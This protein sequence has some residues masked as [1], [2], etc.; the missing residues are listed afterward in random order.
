MAS[1]TANDQ[2]LTL[3]TKNSDIFM[4]LG[5]I[6]ILV[7]MILPLPTWLLDILLS[8][9]I[10]LAIIVLL[11]SMYVMQ[12]L[13]I[14]SFP[15]LLLLTTLFRLGLNI[16]STRL[17]LLNGDQGD[18]AA[19]QVIKA[20]GG[21]V[22]GGNY[23][24]G[25]VVFAI[26]VIINFT[27]ITK[28]AGR[29]AE[30]AARFT[31]DA[32]P[33]RQMSIDA[34][35]NN[36]LIDENEAREKRDRIQ[37]ESDFYGA[38]DGASK[39][40]RGDAV[41]GIIITFINIIGGLFIGVVQKDMSFA[42]AAQTYTLLTVGDGLVSQIPALIISTSAGFIVSRAASDGHMGTQ[43]IS[44]LTIHPRAFVVAA[45][46]LT[47]FGLVPGLPTVPFFG[48]AILAAG[49][50]Y[51]IFQAEKTTQDEATSS[52]EKP[53]V[54]PENVEALLSVDDLELEVG[55]GLIPLV[56]KDQ[57]GDLL[58]RIRSLRRQFA[59][60][61]GVI[62]PPIHIRDNLQL[63]PNQYSFLV[64]GIEVSRNEI[65]VDH[66]LA[67]ESGIVQQKIEGI[68]T[69]EPA[70]GLPAQWIPKDMS[71]KAQ[72]L[73]YTVVDPSS[74][75][76]THIS[77]LLKMHMNE[78]LGRQEVQHLLDKVA[79]KNPKLV[80]ELVPGILPLGSV[81]KVLQNLLRE[82]VSIRNLVTILETLADYGA[83]T[84][85]IDILNEYVRQALNRHITRQ[86]ASDDGNLYLITLDPAL[87]DLLGNAIQHTERESYMNLDPGNAQKLVSALENQV[88]AFTKTQSQP[89]LLCSP[90]VRLNLRRL[91]EK[92]LPQLVVMSNT[93]IDAK[94]PLKS[95]GTVNI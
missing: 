41:A 13:D 28:G 8:C 56:N 16:A 3:L 57:G 60:D 65:M 45:M 53:E 42:D 4:S 94:I 78:I 77:E 54:G 89:V 68:Q 11:V 70:F 18:A 7:I 74:V 58:E 26:L 86:Y 6:A 75:L 51:A 63:S 32:M 24:V 69:T 20:F 40:V 92:F 95:L 87:E 66:A 90:T 50:S 39:F 72:M 14:S 34:D 59:I 44:Q 35:L 2:S 15:S 27:V 21:F 64:R 10:T 67:M 31:L 93:E 49:L 61:M 29:I 84:K 73:G 79:E 38:M 85:N 91:V 43:L 47:F 37:K 80:D 81:Q 12:A 76:A 9:N 17:I 22:V 1:S 5:V 71:E 48:L 23:V 62:V 83:T 30:V 19:G 25:I 33:G 55:Y 82:R 52:E 88:K 46:V 36:G